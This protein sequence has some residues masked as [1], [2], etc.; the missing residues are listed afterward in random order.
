MCIYAHLQQCCVSWVTL[1]KTSTST[2]DWIAPCTQKML[3]HIQNAKI[4]RETLP[5][6]HQRERRSWTLGDNRHTWQAIL[7]TSIQV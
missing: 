7:Y 5:F 3:E 6:M 2:H 4:P 1:Q